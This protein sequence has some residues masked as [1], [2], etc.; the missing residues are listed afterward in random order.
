M[1][2]S[3]YIVMFFCIFLSGVYCVWAIRNYD[4]DWMLPAAR[5]QKEE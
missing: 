1:L 4:E 3:Y 2:L 5:L